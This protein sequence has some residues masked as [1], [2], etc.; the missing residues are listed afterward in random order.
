V[1]IVVTAREDRAGV[2][3]LLHRL[4]DPSRILEVGVLVLANAVATGVRF[5]ALRQLMADRR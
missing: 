1:N 3:R 5:L 4:G 2:A